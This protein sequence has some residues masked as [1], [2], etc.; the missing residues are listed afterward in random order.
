MGAAFVIYLPLFMVFRAAA[1]AYIGFVRSTC[2][3]KIS[4]S[5][6]GSSSMVGSWD[7]G[8]VLDAFP[9]FAVG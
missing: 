5:V 8:A 2:L 6:S 1:L 3:F 7:V 4:S 9:T